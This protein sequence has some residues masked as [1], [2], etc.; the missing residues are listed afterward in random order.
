MNRS[1]DIAQLRKHTSGVG[2]S[3][4]TIQLQQEVKQLCKED[5]EKLLKSLNTNPTI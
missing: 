3:P 2:S 1:H 5:R 4:E